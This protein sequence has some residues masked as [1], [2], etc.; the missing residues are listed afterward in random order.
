LPGEWTLVT[1]T[2]SCRCH[3]TPA[4]QQH[5]DFYIANF[6]NG[7]CRNQVEL[8][9]GMEPAELEHVF[10]GEAPWPVLFVGGSKSQQC[11]AWWN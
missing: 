10:A 4:Y 1:V 5:I 9:N 11:G 3:N 6:W 7:E 8:T 2:G